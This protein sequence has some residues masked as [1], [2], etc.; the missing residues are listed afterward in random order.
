MNKQLL[1]YAASRVGHAALVLF[2]AITLSFAILQF[3]PGDPARLIV[4]GGQEDAG[5]AN[6]AQLAQIRAEMGLDKPVLVQYFGYLLRVLSFDWGQAYSLRQPVTQVIGD[7]LV[8]TVQLG[9][10]SI[11][12]MVALGLLLAVGEALLPTRWLRQVFSSL[13]VLG[14][15]VPSFVMAIILLQVFS[16]KL[17]WFPAFGAGGF[18]SLVLP[19]ITIALLGAGTLSQVF[20]RGI[21][22]VLGENHVLVART[23]GMGHAR[24]VR[25]HVLRNASL[26][27]YTIV[28]MLIGGIVSGAAII[29]TIFGRPGIGNLYVEAVGARDFPLI[30]ALIV[31]TGGIYM[32]ITLLVDLSYPLIDPRV[33]SPAQASRRS[34]R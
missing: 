2:G 13:T 28:G 8:H 11:G 29:E 19:A 26:P 20:S 33:T 4:S 15:G 1:T 18:S 23:K 12:I 22:E 32:V 5:A 25:T 7:G 24:L 14:I 9:A 16:F 10:L 27:V 6:D 17:G 31:L 3:T 34:R 21:R 30:Q